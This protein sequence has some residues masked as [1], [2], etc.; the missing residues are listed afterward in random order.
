MKKRGTFV[1]FVSI[2]SILLITSCSTGEKDQGRINENF[3][4]GWKFHRGDAPG[5]DLSEF[6]ASSWREVDLPHDWSIEDIPGTGSPFD[7]TAIGGRGTGFTVGGTGWYIKDFILDRSFAGKRVD[8]LFEGIYMDA[9]IWVNDHFIDNHPYGYTSFHFDITEQLNFDG[10]P[11]RISVK[12]KNEG[13]NC[14]WYSGSGIYRHVW[15]TATDPVHIRRWGTFVSTEQVTGGVAE[16]RVSTEIR[17]TTGTERVLQVSRQIMD[18]SGNGVA[19]LSEEVVVA[20]FSNTTLQQLISVEDS[21]LWSP[22]TPFLYSM[23]T[24]LQDGERILDQEETTFGIRTVVFDPERGMLLNGKETKLRGGCMH[25][26]NGPLGSA[27]YDRAEERRVEL[28]KANGFNAIRTS[29]NPPSPGFLDAC[30]R[31]GMLVIDELF[32]G[33]FQNSPKK[34]YYHMAF[35]EGWQGDL[36]NFVYRDRNHPSVIMWSTGNE[37]MDKTTLR[38]EKAQQELAGMFRRLDPSRAVTCGVNKWGHENWDTVKAVYMAPLDVVGYNYLVRMYAED[39]NQYPERLIFASESFPKE[40][41]QYW[42]PVLDHPYLIGD[43][44]W[45]GFDYLGEVSIGWHG[46]SEGYPWTVAYCGDIDICGFKRP[47][48]CFREIVWGTGKRVAMFVKNP[49]PTFGVASHSKWDF[50]DVHA[51]WTWPGYEGT[52]MEVVVYSNGDRVVLALNGEEIGTGATGRANEFTAAFRV[53]FEPGS[54]VATAYEGEQEIDRFELVTAGDPAALRMTADRMTIEATGQDLSYLTVEVVDKEGNRIPSAE[55]LVSF[56]VEGA[57]EIIG[58]GSARPNSVE[59]FQNLKR[60][61]FE[62]RCI[63]IVKSAM[64]PG[65]IRVRASAGGLEPALLVLNSE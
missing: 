24:V 11:N 38:A 43:F 22:E 26:D 1:C 14:R 15:L 4:F 13:V 54:L 31:L 7:S 19:D 37:I 44:V 6:D 9:D 27:A 61:T 17:N 23:L 52:S 33:W 64:E 49:V 29:H 3:D 56:T 18:P 65:E 16:I 62:G 39:H 53:P 50:P 60:T 58:V 25:H 57:G 45:T 63:A 59:S 30:D 46:F 20:P 47:Q 51:S 5:A 2:C 36:E 10:T 40:A 35:E 8:L 55:E 32:D 42:M 34:P 48:S 21:Q 41:F 28:M 12:V